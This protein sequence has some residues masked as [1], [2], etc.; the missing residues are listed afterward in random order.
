MQFTVVTQFMTDDG[1]SSGDLVQISRFYV[2][3]GVVIAN[4]E[5]T[6]PGVTGNSITEP[7]CDAQ[8]TAFG[9]TNTFEQQGGLTQMGEAFKA[10]MVLVLSIWDDATS[11]MLWLDSDYPPTANP[12]SPGVARG[13]CPTS[14]GQLE[15][16]EAS[17]ADAFVIFSNIKISN[18][19]ATI[20]PTPP[21]PPGGGPSTTSTKSITSSVTT[22]STTTATTV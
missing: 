13:P 7:L 12:T 1:T 19:N 11:N 18:I 16:V 10:G 6:I 22:T 5:S 15:T 14:S 20:E 3:N 9:D 2:Q 21:G 4:S 17:D 8:K